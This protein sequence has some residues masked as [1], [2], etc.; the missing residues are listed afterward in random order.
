[1]LF[2]GSRRP[3]GEREIGD[4]EGGFAGGDPDRG[5]QDRSS[6]RIGAHPDPGWFTLNINSDAAGNEMKQPPSYPTE[7]RGT[8][9]EFLTG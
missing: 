6:V 4:A 9:V 8:F 7:S 2:H 5:S 3:N 1:M